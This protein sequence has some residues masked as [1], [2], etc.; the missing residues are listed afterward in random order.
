MAT[1][2]SYGNI[3]YQKHSFFIIFSLS[4]PK[5]DTTHMYVS[6][7]LLL[8]PQFLIRFLEEKNL[9]ED[10]AQMARIIFRTS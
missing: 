1:T 10:E 2:F 7:Y 5:R 4:T 8:S 9:K 6:H 3:L